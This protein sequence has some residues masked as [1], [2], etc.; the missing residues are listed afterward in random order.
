MNILLEP[1]KRD[2]AYTAIFTHVAEAFNTFIRLAMLLSHLTVIILFFYNLLDFQRSGLYKHEYKKWR[3]IIILYILSYG[4][5]MYWTVYT[6][7]PLIVEF[8]ISF[9]STELRFEP[10]IHEFLNIVFTSIISFGFISTIPF[11]IIFINPLKNLYSAS[12]E[13]S[14]KQISYPRPLILLGWSIL[15]SLITP[16]DLLSLLI[17]TGFLFLMG[18]LTLCALFIKE[19]YKNKKTIARL[20]HD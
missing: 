8:F 12:G 4:L 14:H 11:I 6:F 9:E 18:E 5:I 3:I 1:L 7:L 15:S 13:I 19:A 2:S 17:V 16:P 10:R 20:E